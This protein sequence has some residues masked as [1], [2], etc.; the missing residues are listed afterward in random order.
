V[1]LHEL[2]DDHYGGDGDDVLRRMLDEG[3]DPA[4]RYGP[5]SETPLH[6]AT[7]RR[8]LSAVSILLERGAPIDALSAGGKTAYA[9]AIRRSFDEVA[10]ALLAAGASDRLEPVDR[11]AVAVGGGRLDEARAHLANHPGVA[12]TGNPEE[13]RLLAD[14]AGRNAPGPVAFLIEAGADLAARGLDTGTP[15]HQAAWFGQPDNA[16]LLIGAGAPLDIFDDKHESSPIH[17]GVHGSRYSGGADERQD[18]YVAVV[19]LLL[20]AGSSL[21]YPGEP[22]GDAYLQRLRRDASPRVAELL[23]DSAPEPA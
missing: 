3:A 19:R 12:R 11:F 10:E 21:R 13:D 1:T 14:M 5:E 18:A 6:T 4:A 8:R 22:A 16:R 15:L 20:D 23:P 2:L 17:W 7:R 9:H